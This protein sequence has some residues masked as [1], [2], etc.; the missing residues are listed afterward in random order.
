MSSRRPNGE[1]NLRLRKNG[2][3]E[4]A[5]CSGLGTNGKKRTKSFYGRTE[6]E[7]REKAR[8]F[9]E[10]QEAGLEVYRNITFGKWADEWYQGYQGQV[11]ASTYEGYRYTLK[12]LKDAFGTQKL[13][14]IKAMH[15]ERFLRKMV[16]M[17]R[18][19][20]YVSKLRGMMFQ[21]MNKALANDLIV[22]NPV[23]CTDKIRIDSNQLPVSTRDSFTVQEIE[24][25]TILLPDD[26][27][28]H[29][30]RLML[31]TGMRTQELL[32]L[33]PRHIEEDGSWIYIRQA[34]T[35]VKGTPQIGP[36]KTKTSYRDVPVPSSL[37]YSARVLRNTKERYVWH[38]EEAALCNP[39]VFRKHFKKMLEQ[40]GEVRVLSPHCCRHT[41]VS[42]LQ[43][44]GVPL[45]TIQNLSGHAKLNMT[46]HYLHIQQ[47][48]KKKAVDQLN[49]LFS[50]PNRQESEDNQTEKSL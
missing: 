28:G 13:N 1:G 24:L 43:A 3:W 23:A 34:V 18:S 39:S 31:G 8:R 40:V 25:L 12:I 41:Y 2:I 47:E 30:I 42:Q 9:F 14:N 37:M 16:E 15:I 36:P 27:I 35:M 49:G 19:K 6:K 32:A 45:E 7:V 48:V 26:R 29:S 22:K 44:A 20:S 10:E 50:C 5:I 21:I 38:G 33:E 11:S 17:G 46:E 4:L